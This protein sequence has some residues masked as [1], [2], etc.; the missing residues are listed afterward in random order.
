MTRKPT[1]ESHRKSK[2]NP[3]IS[4]TFIST[5]SLGQPILINT[6]KWINSNFNC[7]SWK[8]IICLQSLIKSIENIGKSSFQMGY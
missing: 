4:A 7:S 2:I 1:S 5:L 8:S 6:F 3:F